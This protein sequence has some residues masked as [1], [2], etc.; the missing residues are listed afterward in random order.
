MGLTLILPYSLFPKTKCDAHRKKILTK[1][2]HLPVHYSLSPPSLLQ[3]KTFVV[4]TMCSAWKLHFSDSFADTIL[5]N[6]VWGRITGWGSRKS[7]KRVSR[8]CWHISSALSPSPL[9]C[10]ECEQECDHYIH[11][12]YHALKGCLAWSLML[13][14]HHLEILS[15]L[16]LCSTSESDGTTEHA[17]GVLSCGSLTVLS[18]HK[19][20]MVLGHL[21][22]HEHPATT[23]TL[24]SY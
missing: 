6:E 5:A 21:L 18:P 10:L 8:L 11:I 24:Y 3:H 7:P 12:G 13:C 1:H 14:G 16:D 17:V 20:G 22:A 4:R 23:A 9:A 15:N 2:C 19:L